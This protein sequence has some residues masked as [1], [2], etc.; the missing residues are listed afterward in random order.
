MKKSRLKIHFADELSEKIYFNLLNISEKEDLRYLSKA[1][2]LSGIDPDPA[3]QWYM[4]L[5]EMENNGV[6]LILYGLGETARTIW[7]TEL[8][9]RGTP[10]YLHFP[11]LG[12]I[13]WFGVCDKNTDQFP[14]GF[15]GKKVMSVD[16]L[17][18]LKEKNICVCIG[19]PDYYEEI[20]KE[21]IELGIKKEQI[22]RHIYPK[23]I[24][25]EDKQYFD[26][27][28]EVKRES[29]VIDGGC[30]RCDSLE[31]FIQ[32]NKEKGYDRIITYEPDPIN[33]EICKNKI[34]EES[35]NNVE[36]IHA[37]LSD[38]EYT[39]NF[40]GNGDDTSYAS[41][42]GSNQTQ[43]LSIDKCTA[44]KHVSF[45]K[46]DVEGFELETL[47]GAEECIKRNHP[48]MAISLYHK[49]EDLTEI[50]Y[51]IQTLSN[52]YK[53]YLRIYSNAYLEIILYAIFGGGT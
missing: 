40:M 18:L 12:D 26:D 49:A 21:L 42:D 50:P 39:C 20:E 48:R 43:M 9:R 53:F 34:E 7:Q 36:I 45:I 16:E 10:G 11:F 33:Y 47:K 5:K 15:L 24:C 25:Y 6:Q 29:T 37:G 22:V 2:K 52:S 41:M 31:R 27:F 14:N 28:M 17:L 23:T 44:G 35:W 51:Y 38:K 8:D 46:L 13:D 32:W 1:I 4:D 30:F 19:A 3:Y